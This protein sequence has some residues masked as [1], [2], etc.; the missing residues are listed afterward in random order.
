MNREARRDH[1]DGS[2][3]LRVARLGPNQR[4]SQDPGL[5]SQEGARQPL[6]APLLLGAP[7]PRS[8]G[9]ARRPGRRR[10]AREHTQ[11]PGGEA[12]AARAGRAGRPGRGE[13]RA[14]KRDEPGRECPGWG[15]GSDPPA[16]SGTGGAA[17]SGDAA[18]I[19]G[20]PSGVG[21]G[22]A[23][24]RGLG[25]RGEG[26]RRGSGGPAG[27]GLGAGAGGGRPGRAAGRTWSAK[28]S[29]V[30]IRSFWPMAAAGGSARSARSLARRSARRRPR[31]LRP[32]QEVPG[33]R[34]RSS[35]AAP[36]AAT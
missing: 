33:G 9:E 34:P 4:R 15:R 29:A 1:P 12:A 2:E 7:G 23:G 11:S 8:G 28:S 5:P 24:G 3:G 14:G 16:G 36:A 21:A 35:S 13:P 32:P 31:P 26:G 27:G 6:H 10:V 17:R 30:P 25:T 19:S 20:P 22:S 18:Q